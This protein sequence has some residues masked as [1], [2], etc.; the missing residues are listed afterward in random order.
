MHEVMKI[1]EE[2]MD[3]HFYN[4]GLKEASLNLLCFKP[5]MIKIQSLYLQSKDRMSDNRK[6]F[7]STNHQ[8]VNTQTIHKG[9]CS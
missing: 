7:Q 4:F 2:N 6:I 9:K 3:D 1:V 5:E 8:K